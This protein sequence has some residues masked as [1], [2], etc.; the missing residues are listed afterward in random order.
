MKLISVL[1]VRSAYGAAAWALFDLRVGLDTAYTEYLPMWYSDRCVLLC[2]NQFGHLTDYS[3]DALHANIMFSLS[4]ALMIFQAQ[5]ELLYVLEEV[6]KNLLDMCPA[7]LSLR[8]AQ[9]LLVPL[10][11]RCRLLSRTKAWSFFKRCTAPTRNP[12]KTVVFRGQAFVQAMKNAGFTAEESAGSSVS[13]RSS[14]GGSICF[15]RP[16]PDPVLH[17][18]MLYAMAKRL[19][20]WFGFTLETFVLK[21]TEVAT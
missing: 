19:T 18:I 11:H 17:P 8:M 10:L 7:A 13:F 1:H 5:Y 6:L 9:A 21:E 16:H 2:C 20:K 12:R 4:K 15:H 3:P 14:H